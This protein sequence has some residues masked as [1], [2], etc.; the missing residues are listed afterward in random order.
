MFA[1]RRGSGR[2]E[3]KVA[4]HGLCLRGHVGE[5][6]CRLPLGDLVSHRTGTPFRRKK[7]EPRRRDRCEVLRS[8][9]NANTSSGS[10]ETRCVRSRTEVRIDLA[11]PRWRRRTSAG[12]V[13]VP[14]ASSVG[15]DFNFDFNTYVPQRSVPLV[16]KGFL[17]RQAACDDRGQRGGGSC[18]R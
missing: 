18:S 14:W 3:N 12:W 1:V 5:R 16:L 9:K 11:F 6:S 7:L 4:N 13:D 15:S 2:G 10:D 17:F 8:A